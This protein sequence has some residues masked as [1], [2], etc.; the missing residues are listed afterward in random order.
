MKHRGNYDEIIDLL[1][2]LRELKT[3]G[4]ITEKEFG[5]KKKELLNKIA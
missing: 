5:L 2:K 4:T 1:R 3:T